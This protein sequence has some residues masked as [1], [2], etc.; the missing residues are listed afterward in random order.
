MEKQKVFF[1]MPFADEFFEVYEMLKQQFSDLFDFSNA[2]DECNQ[3]NIL[4]DIV[5]P[6]YEADIIVAD[7]TGLNP[8][9]MYELGL[10]HSFN[11]KTIIIT[12]D[13]LSN[14]PFDL[15]QYRA[16]DY[17]THFK[18]FAGLVSYLETNLKGAADDS[19]VYSNPVKDFLNLNGIDNV[20]WFSAQTTI[21]L[22]DDSDK[23]FL[24]YL[25]EIESNVE[26]LTS[27]F[28]DMAT[29]MLEMTAGI[30]ESSSNISRVKNNGG[31]GTAS[32]ARKTIKKAAEHIDLFSKKLRD[33]NSAIEA[34]WDEIEK[35]TI[36]LLESPH[37]AKPENS[38]SII[39]YLKSLHEM[40]NAAQ[41]SAEN[42][43]V[44]KA[45]LQNSI[46]IERTLN[47]AIRFATQ[48]LTAYIGFADRLCASVDKI[49]QKSRFVVGEINF[50]DLE[51]NT[52]IDE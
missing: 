47:Q 21:E 5:Q 7:L 25:A 30:E 49:L 17:S 27:N 44:L 11:K 16:K 48:D 51:S 50:D 4:K 6:I 9:V 8:N 24:D 12:Q 15:K 22:P 34:H 39:K 42:L 38:V 19:V 26:N 36:G 13:E 31:N 2:A 33:H 3:Q 32:F 37:S 23:G 35:N 52:D 10:A 43:E 45:S 40:K 14:L 29:E 18:Q 41:L 28:N 46:G 1:I 20:S